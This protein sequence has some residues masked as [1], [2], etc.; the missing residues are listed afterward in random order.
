MAPRIYVSAVPSVVT[1]KRSIF[2][3]LFSSTDPTTVGVYPSTFPVFIDAAT[4]TTLTRGQLKELALCFG[5]GLLRHPKLAR[6]KRGDTLLIFLSNSITFPVVLFG[7]VAA[8]IK[9]S[10]ANTA[11]VSRELKHQYTDSGAIIIATSLEGLPVVQDMFRSL[12]IDEEEQVKR[13]V[14]IGNGLGWAGGPDSH[15]EQNRFVRMEELLSLGTLKREEPFDDLAAHE[16]CYICYSSGTTGKPKGVETTHA[17]LTTVVDI[18]RPVTS[19]YHGQDRLLGVL[20]FFHIYGAVALLHVPIMTG[21]PVIIQTRFDPTQFC[22]NIEKFKIT[23]AM[24]VP[25]V[26]VVLARHPAVDAYNLS[27]LRVAFSAAAPLGN[28]LIMQ[29]AERF[30]SKGSSIAVMQGYGLTETSPITHILPPSVALQKAGSIGIL[31]PNLEAR[32]V[33]D[34]DGEGL[35]D[36][37]EGEPGELWIRGPTIMKGYLNNKNATVEA[38]TKDG[39]FKSGDICIRD[40][41]GFYWIVDRRKELIKYKGFQVPPSELESV[42]LTHPDIA[43]AAVIGV[44]NPTEATEMPRAY[45]V[46]ADPTRIRTQSA[47]DTFSQRVKT[48]IESKVASHKFLRGGVVVIEEIPKSAAGKILRRELR[49]RAKSETAPAARAKL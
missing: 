23:V 15:I 26:L 5:Y 24:V 42:L 46:H 41:E 35:V 19:I 3:H 2:T 10:P 49:E 47:R 36:A 7:A 18:G 21:S 28:E 20:P 32:I 48:W 9:C 14:V 45:V 43:D 39:W 27:S 13:I 38:I 16:T 11:Y 8:G 12:G 29:V 44:N 31:L 33:V 6:Q 30:H 34:G 22:A 17:N 37:A 25:P 4:G 1:Y 40:K